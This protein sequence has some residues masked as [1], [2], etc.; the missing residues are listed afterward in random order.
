M[1]I[2]IITAEITVSERLSSYL[3]AEYEIL[4]LKSLDELGDFEGVLVVY[5]DKAYALL[6]RRLQAYTQEN[7]LLLLQS[8][9]QL[10]EGEHYLSLGIKGYGNV[11][12]TQNVLRQAIEIIVSDNI[13]V[14]PEL[15]TAII[16]K[17]AQALGVE[18]S[19]NDILGQLTP[20]EVEVAHLI[21]AGDSNYDITQKLAISL[22][23]VKLHIHAIF[24][25]LEVKNRVA[26]SMKLEGHTL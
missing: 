23:T 17:R 8:L 22:S 2:A 6:S 26:L 21:G 25:K 10:D 11:Q 16:Q 1:K 18:E 3:S 5:D 13:W 24:E 9:P 12:M 7:K 14:Y 20:R 15:M 19:K 4:C